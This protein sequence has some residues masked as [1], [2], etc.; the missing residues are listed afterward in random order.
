MVRLSCG[1]KITRGILVV[2]NVIF[3][4]FGLVLFGFGIY[5]TAAKKFDVAFFE[6]VKVD[7][8]GG[9]AI[10]NIGIIILLVGFLTVVLS[11][12]GGLGMSKEI[13]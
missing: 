1:L 9:T 8:I 7:M 2:L 3:L 11:I 10:Q 6:D 5:L 13:Y 4:I 12:I